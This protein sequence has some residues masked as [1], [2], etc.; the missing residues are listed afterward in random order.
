[1]SQNM[2]PHPNMGGSD[3][4]TRILCFPSVAR[5]G[6]NYTQTAWFAPP[7]GPVTARTTA[8]QKGYVAGVLQIKQLGIEEIDERYVSDTCFEEA[9][10]EAV[11]R[12]G[13]VLLAPKE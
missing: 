6:N 1:M 11:A 9:W 4:R 3:G 2:K 8:Y 5:D 10:A 13:Y 7:G 12:T